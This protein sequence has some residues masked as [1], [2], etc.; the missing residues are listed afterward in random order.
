[1]GCRGKRDS[2]SCVQLPKVGL[3]G[4]NAM[5]LKRVMELHL[6]SLEGSCGVT[7]NPS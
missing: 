4:L 6:K 7:C 1:M 5:P 3:R 2:E